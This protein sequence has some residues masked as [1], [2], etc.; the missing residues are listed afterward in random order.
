MQSPIWKQTTTQVQR[1]IKLLTNL[2]T[3]LDKVMEVDVYH[4]TPLL[5][6]SSNLYLMCEAEIARLTAQLPSELT[7][8]LSYWD[9]QSSRSAI[10]T[11]LKNTCT[12]YNV[13]YPD[14]VTF[15]SAL[16][17]TCS[18][19]FTCFGK[20]YVATSSASSKVAAEQIALS[21]LRSQM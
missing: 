20:T 12:V 7:Q 13:P 8:F 19:R 17:W 21:N 15:A 16:T 5:T 9:D 2:K 4:D 3:E 18:L 10:K 1:S 14:V 6:A 11:A